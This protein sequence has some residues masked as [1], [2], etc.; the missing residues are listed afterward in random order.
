[1]FLGLIKNISFFP[2]SYNNNICLDCRNFDFKSK[3][4]DLDAELL[5]KVEDFCYL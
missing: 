1:M 3:F 4:S 5:V 2:I